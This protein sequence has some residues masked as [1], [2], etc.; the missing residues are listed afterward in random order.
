MKAKTIKAVLRKKIDGWLESIEDEGLRERAKKD[1]IVTGGAIASM[2]LKEPVNDFDVYFRTFETTRN[3]AIYYLGRFKPKLKNGVAC[4]LHVQSGTDELGNTNR[5]RIVVKSAGIASEEGAA[6]PYQYFE[7]RPADEAGAYIGE[8]MDDL[9]AIEDAYEETQEAAQE[10]PDEP[11]GPPY[12]PIFLST[13]AITLAN[14]IQIILRFHGE[15]DQ[16]H[17]NYDFVHCTCYWTSHDNELVLRP[18]ALEAL[19]ARELRYV[20]SKY[21]L[22]SLI[23]LRKFIRRHWTINAGQILKMV[24]Q[25]SELNLKN[26]LILQDQLTGVDCAYF[27]EIMEKMKEKDPE[28]VN[29]AYLC[30]II[31]RMF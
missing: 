8:V 9:G 19:L 14:K 21:P 11:G 6:E 30:E 20:G 17:E 26:H 24:M 28:K 7:G 31:D 15:P 29:S 10:T 2:L 27:V 23:R 3:V 5:V 1:A 4:P 13:N 18:A 22:C 25:L 16:I 12:R